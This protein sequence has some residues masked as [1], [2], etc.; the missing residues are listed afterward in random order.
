MGN[1]FIMKSTAFIHSLFSVYFYRLCF[2]GQHFSL[3]SKAVHSSWQLLSLLN[4]IFNLQTLKF[5]LRSLMS[6]EFLQSQVSCIYNDS[7]SQEKCNTFGFSCASAIPPS[8]VLPYKP[9]PL[10][11]LP[12]LHF[13]LLLAI[14]QM[15]PQIYLA[16]QIL[17]I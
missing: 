4:Y 11:Y 3:I 16:F 7:I 6:Y 5:T 1:N 12:S 15:Q 14:I 2:Q 17:F 8:C 10:I 9:C 13:C